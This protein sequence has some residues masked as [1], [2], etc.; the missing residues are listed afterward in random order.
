MRGAP[1]VGLLAASLLAIDAAHHVCMQRGLR[2]DEVPTFQ[3]RARVLSVG[4]RKPAGRKLTFRLDATGAAVTAAGSTWSDWLIFDRPRVEA[5]LREYPATSL[6]AFPLVVFLR[7][8]GV[9]D[10]TRVE[11]ELRFVEA[12]QSFVLD[13][14]LFGPTLGVLIWRDANRRPRAATMANYNQRYWK[15]MEGAQVPRAQRPR[16]FPLVDRFI[17]GDD[18]RLN[19]REGIEQLARA[20]MSA[21]MLPASRPIRE[22]LLQAGLHRTAWAVYNPP[23][24]AFNFGDPR[25]PAATAAE[26]DAWATQ[27]ARPYL[28]AGYVREEM[29][30]FAMSDEPGWYYPEMLQRL[31]RDPVALARFHDYLKAQNLLP[32]E[33]GASRWGEVLPIGCSQASDLP[34]R[35][36]FYWT[37]RFFARDSSQHFARCSRALEKAFYPNVPVFTNWNFFSGRFYVPGPVANN[38]DKESRDAAMGGQDWFEFGRLRGGTMLW[39]E[40]WFPDSKAYQ[41]SF[42]AAKLRSAAAK[43][44][45]PFGGYIVPRAA[46]D[47][48]D[49]IVQKV[50]CLLGNG[51]KAIQ[52]Y[53]FGP[54]YNF[55]DNCYSERASV[56]RKIA[57]ANRMIGRAE[58]LLWPGKPPRAEVAILAP[59]SA[60]VW[61]AHG[62][63]LP[64]QI[65]DSTNANLNG[66]TVDYLAEVADLY[67]ALQHQNIPVEFADEDDLSPQGLKPYRVLYV[68]APDLPEEGQRGIVAWVRQGGTLVTVTGAGARGRYDEPCRVLSDFTGIGE[69][70]RERLLVPNLDALAAV[71]RA[72]GTLGDFTAIGARGTLSRP[73]EQVEASFTDGSPAI[74]R[75]ALG[76]GRVVH[77]AWMPGLSYAKS[78]SG[79]KDHLPIGFSEAVRHWIVYPTRLAGIR[80]PVT[81]D[82]A[83]VETPLMCSAG[84]AVATLL[85]WTGERLTRVSLSARVPFTVQNVESI[86]RG[87]LPFRRSQEGVTFALPLGAA[88]IV[89]LRP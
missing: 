65:Q 46:G 84:G 86:R 85:N 42:Y 19:W 89:T 10:P 1:L 75:R 2:A 51:G 9:V 60:Q 7:V 52:Y 41:W 50:L 72:H 8:D 38:S 27:Q 29:A 6:R 64:P 11:A 24:Y 30:L 35:R 5:R 54:E 83:M 22:L 31:I 12:G 77:F 40:D 39:T 44:G 81:V 3:L 62:I 88:D 48:E 79:M 34:A 87:P 36:L 16:K 67:L 45:V 28:E 57:E 63:P 43:T 13:G 15:L 26:I 53:V 73:P 20:G 59:R 56:L 18:D 55:P 66:S 14:D 68:T 49:G 76:Q 80:P 71:G 61:D 78:A 33:M 82:R 32:A 37:M 23:G 70:P 74:V 58:D 25:T 4:G 47:R 69:E 21:L 17:G